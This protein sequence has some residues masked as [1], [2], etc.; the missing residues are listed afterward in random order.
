MTRRLLPLAAALALAT[1]PACFLSRNQ[2]NTSLDEAKIQALAPGQST[3]DDVLDAL[4]APSDVVQLGRRSAWRYDHSTGKTAAFTI[5]IVTLV[6]SDV[7]TDRVWAF[8][9]END[10]LTHLSG[11]FEADEA[12]YKMPFQD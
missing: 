3:A 5:L 4:G 12:S 2:L 8:F 10:V 7:K 11:T 1:T 6:N 9:D